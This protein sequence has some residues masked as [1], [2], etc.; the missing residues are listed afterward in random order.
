MARQGWVVAG[1]DDTP[2]GYRDHLLYR[3]TSRWQAFKA[4]RAALRDDMRVTITRYL[5]AR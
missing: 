4:V 1:D 5:I 3:G 2:D